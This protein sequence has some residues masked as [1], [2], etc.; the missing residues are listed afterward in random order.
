M[1]SHIRR[2]IKIALF[3]AV[4]FVLG[5]IESYIPVMPHIPGGKLGF[6]NIISVIV[7]YLYGAKY[8]LFVSIVRAFLSGLL[9]SGVNALMYSVSG[10]F[11][12]VVAMVIVLKIFK[13]K[14]S[15]IGVCVTGALFNNIAQ[16][17]V[18]AILVSDMSIFTYFCFL[19]PISVISGIATGFGANYV[20]KY[21]KNLV[22]VI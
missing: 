2:N 14:V 20:L 18:A 9:F 6:A 3:I 5:V 15:P 8:A 1:K 10:A 11:L 19:A 7:L 12:S 4:A 21:K 17:V 13:D 22:G 16:I